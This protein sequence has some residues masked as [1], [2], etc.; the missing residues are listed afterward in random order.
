MF[1]VLDCDNKGSLDY[2]E[3]MPFFQFTG[4]GRGTYMLNCGM[5]EGQQQQTA[6]ISPNKRERINYKNGNSCEYPVHTTHVS[7]LLQPT[8]DDY[9]VYS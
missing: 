4:D 1:S 2:D 7:Y 5:D 8:Q 6:Y 9:N 3:I